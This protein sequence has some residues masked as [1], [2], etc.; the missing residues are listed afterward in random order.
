MQFAL[1]L[2]PPAFMARLF[3]RPQRHVTRWHGAR[4][5]QGTTREFPSSGGRLT[6]HC[7]EGEAW[8]THDGDPRDVFIAAKQS[9]TADRGDR[10]TLHALA[11][12]CV[13]EIE[14]ELRS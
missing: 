4:V 14:E 5:P 12:D 8:I 6:V 1:A 3:A 2:Q 13:V 7:R 11:G 9:Y 10:L